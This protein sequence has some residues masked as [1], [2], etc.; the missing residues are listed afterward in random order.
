VIDATD[1][2][3]LRAA[4]FTEPQI[5][6]L[7]DTIQHATRDLVT[8]DHLDMRLVELREHIDSGFGRQKTDLLR[9]MFAFQVVA[10]LGL[11]LAI[12]Y[13]G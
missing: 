5:S 2:E 13:G 4:G 3:R 12:R 11:Y 10:A 1:L 8:R 7:A 6:A 9:W